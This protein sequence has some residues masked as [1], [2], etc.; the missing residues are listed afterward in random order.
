MAVLTAKRRLI[1][2][3]LLLCLFFI[4]PILA[5]D[6][7]LERSFT[8]ALLA[9][10][11][12]D[13]CEIFTSCCLSQCGRRRVAEFHC[14]QVCQP[15]GNKTLLLGNHSDAASSVCAC[16]KTTSSLHIASPPPLVCQ[17][18]TPPPPSP[19][20]PVGFL[21]FLPRLSLAWNLNGFLQ[22]LALHFIRA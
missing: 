19:S 12:R 18:Q 16:S 13:P 20:A 17:L 22:W 7:E 3:N 9:H 5:T 15:D 21:G 14:A 4:I 8:C 11:W 6:S 1:M 2:H 10:G